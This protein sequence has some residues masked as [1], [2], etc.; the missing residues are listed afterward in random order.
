MPHLD[1]LVP[2]SDVR[3]HH[4]FTALTL[5]RSD[6]LELEYEGD[7]VKEAKELFVK[8]AK[9]G[10]DYNDPLVVKLYDHI[11]SFQKSKLAEV[12]QQVQSYLDSL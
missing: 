1:E 9:T 10:A 12:K 2:P 5:A 11:D 3:N 4:I 8:L 6:R 7:E